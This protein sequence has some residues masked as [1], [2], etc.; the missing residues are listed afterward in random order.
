MRS[1]RFD[2]LLAPAGMHYGKPLIGR[3]AVVL[4]GSA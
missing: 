3:T 1:R 4:R 2:A